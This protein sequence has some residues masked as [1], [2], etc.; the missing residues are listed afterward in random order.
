MQSNASLNAANVTVEKLGSNKIRV[1]KTD[2]MELN[3]DFAAGFTAMGFTGATNVDSAWSDLVIE[4]KETQ[5]TGE[6]AEG[7]LWYNSDLKI[8]ILKNNFNGTAMEWQPHAW[9]EDADG[10]QATELQLR[11]GMPTA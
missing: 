3:I 5:I 4:A 1:S 10:L 2:G 6:V 8:E 7:T 9:S 11:T